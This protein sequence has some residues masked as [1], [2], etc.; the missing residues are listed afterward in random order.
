[1]KVLD[2]IRANEWWGYKFPPMLACGYFFISKGEYQLSEV[3]YS[4]CVIIVALTIGATYVSVINDFTDLK[5]DYKAGKYNR[6]S[7]L[8]EN[9]RVV[10]LLASIILILL[11]LW[12][13]HQQ[14]I[15][16]IFYLSAF[17]SFTFY[18]LPP[19]RLKN[20]GLYGVIAD[21]A[22]SQLFPTLFVISVLSA[23]LRIDVQLFDVILVGIWSFS[24]GV[25]GIL[26]HQFHDMEND[27]KSGNNPWVQKLGH[28]E[29]KLIGYALICLESLSLFFLI[30]DSKLYM[31]LIFVGLYLVYMYLRYKRSNL[32]IVLLK[33]SRN[34]FSIFLFEFYQV[35]LPISL[36]I[37]LIANSVQYLFLLVF[38]VLLFHSGI[39]NVV[40]N[41]L[42]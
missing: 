21:A 25:R 12:F 6:L 16:M 37:V 13:L 39:Y 18:S 1:M 38:H 26:W 2:L 8:R 4:L 5:D 22:G 31:I 33:H 17:M 35:F 9:K 29:I 32:E 11:V 36:L 40:K 23:I 3:L 15:S 24:F 42:K 7:I 28:V 19:F 20:K 41:T 34:N 27:I 30:I 14:T 10:F